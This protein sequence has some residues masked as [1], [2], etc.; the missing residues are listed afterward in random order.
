MRAF[1]L[2]A[3]A[4]LALVPGI[5]Q[6]AEPACL[7]PGEFSSL[8]AYA[9]PSMINGTT[10]RCS[11]TL[12]PDAFLRKSGGELATRYAAQK[13]GSWAGAKTALFKL[14]LAD[15]TAINS[16]IA[17]LPD[18]SLMQIFD[19]TL[20]GL[21]EQNIPVEKCAT[22]DSVIRLLAPLPPTNTAELIALT[23]GLASKSGKARVGKFSLCEN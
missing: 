2:F 9:L 19:L 16:Q 11:A 21:V 6:A 12:K 23:V 18:E 7:S 15:N 22:I 8:A 17:T 14:G 13:Q 5:A 3:A 10:K 20:E 4:S 1:A